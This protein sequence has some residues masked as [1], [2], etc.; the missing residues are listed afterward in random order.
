MT[1]TESD[2]KKLA[3]GKSYQ[4]G[5]EYL[6]S[7]AVIDIQKRGNILVSEVEGSNYDPYIVKVELDNNSIISTSCTCP[8][9]WG[10]I[11]K[12]VV[13]VLLNFIHKPESVE[14]QPTVSELL[15]NLNES[16][17][18][19]LLVD[20]LESEPHLIGH[21]EAKIA[22]FSVSGLKIQY[23]SDSSASP[24]KPI[25]IDVSLLKKQAK[26]I[27]K[28]ADRG[29][30]Y[31]SYYYDDDDGYSG[32]P[33]QFMELFDDKVKPLLEAGDANN[34]LLVLDAVIE[35]FIDSWSDEEYYDDISDM[36]DEALA[37]FTEAILS[38]DLSKKE[39]ENWKAKL[40]D[41]RDELSG[42]GSSDSF[43]APL[44]ALEHGWD[45]PPLKSVLEGNITGQ[46]EWEMDAEGEYPE[47]A[48]DF[49]IIRLRVLERKGRRQE[50]LY[51]AEAEGLTEYYLTML[52]KLGRSKEAVNH[53]LQYG[54]VPYQ[55]MIFCNTLKDK[56][57]IK[58]ALKIA[59]HAL[60]AEVPDGESVRDNHFLLLARWLRD[61]GEKQADIELAL[62]GAEAAFKYSFDLKDYLSV[63]SIAKAVGQWEQLKADLLAQLKKKA[64]DNEKV[65]IYLHE[66][67]HR[68]IIEVID[69][70]RGWWGGFS[71]I[72]SVVDAVRKEFPAWA[73]RQCMKQAEPNMDQGKSKYYEYS[74]RWVERA[75]EIYI[76][77]NRRNEWSEYLEGLIK[78]HHKKYSLR[79]QLEALRKL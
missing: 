36:L 45:Y 4:R 42:Y 5:K 63:E 46:G 59:D 13:A 2:V 57:F 72:E 8:Y 79:P 25:V 31:D 67:M 60:S 50:Y 48:Y 61:N 1:I 27:F 26:R 35:T 70:S 62:K 52:V 17:L 18:R 41:W 39:K 75:G 33:D 44:A 29:E 23:S 74:V 21:V 71:K 34:A 9:D 56:G 24:H 6:D 20:L 30:Y 22:S 43:D 7:N 32:I 64:S 77:S 49:N 19:V 58:D 40:S 68:Q 55:A 28:N 69:N 53:A 38:L 14:E 3:Q 16:E 54:L 51:L 65:D 12:H 11:C 78:K 10:G 66:G 76:E 73:I 47:Y 15:V 37:L